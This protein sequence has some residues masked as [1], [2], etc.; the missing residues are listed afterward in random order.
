MRID[1]G[2]VLKEEGVYPEAYERPSHVKHYTRHGFSVP[3]RKS[4][5]S[6]YTQSSET[7]VMSLVTAE[8]IS[9][10]G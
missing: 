1:S 4:P 10:R 9:R 2:S 7:Y 6:K 3:E 8:P 5:T